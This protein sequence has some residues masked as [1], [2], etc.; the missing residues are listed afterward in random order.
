MYV[1]MC[2]HAPPC[3]GQSSKGKIHVNQHVKSQESPL[4]DPEEKHTKTNVTWGS[5][6]PITTAKIH[7]SPPPDQSMKL[8]H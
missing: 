2:I 5:L 1:S 3:F 4:I 7:S 8:F 6:Q